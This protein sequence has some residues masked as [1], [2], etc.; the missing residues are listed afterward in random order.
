M[1]QLVDLGVVGDKSSLLEGGIV[2]NAG[3]GVQEVGDHGGIGHPV[4]DSSGEVA[5]GGGLT[6]GSSVGTE[7]GGGVLGSLLLSLAVA[8]L[9]GVSTL[10]LLL[11][12]SAVVSAITITGALLGEGSSKDCG[13]EK[14][15]DENVLH[16]ECNM[17][18]QP[19]GY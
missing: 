4:G 5:C 18:D 9:L 1:V 11:L 19:N 13:G 17:S 3:T 6:V 15:G 14:R 12:V 10:L 16:C 2:L 8:L 7:T